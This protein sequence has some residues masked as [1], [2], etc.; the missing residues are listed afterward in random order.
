MRKSHHYDT[1]MLATMASNTITEHPLI[2][3]TF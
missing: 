1:L 2:V 3:T